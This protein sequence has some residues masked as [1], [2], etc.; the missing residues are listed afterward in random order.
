MAGR[1]FGCNKYK[2]INRLFS[3]ANRPAA[4]SLPRSPA[5]RRRNEE[6]IELEEERE[7][8]SKEKKDI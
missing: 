1:Y 2:T 5:S 6:S 4:S 7:K 8:C 3:H